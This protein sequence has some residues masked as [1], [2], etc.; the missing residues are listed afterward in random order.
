VTGLRAIS[1]Y[2]AARTAEAYGHPLTVLLLTMATGGSLLWLLASPSQ[3]SLGILL[4]LA[5]LQAS[6]GIQW[7]GSEDTKAI[8]QMVEGLV[9]VSDAPN[10]LINP[11]SAPEQ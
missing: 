7:S 2:I 1:C 11:E 8:K 4:S 3:L 5:A 6:S 9:R 10:E